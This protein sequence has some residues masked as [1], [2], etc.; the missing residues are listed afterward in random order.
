[1]GANYIAGRSVA[2]EGDSLDSGNSPPLVR[3]RKESFGV[4]YSQSHHIIPR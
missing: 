1:M 4:E 2:P 3:E